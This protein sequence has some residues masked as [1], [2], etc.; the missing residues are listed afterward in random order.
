MIFIL[1]VRQKYKINTIKNISKYIVNRINMSNAHYAKVK[2][3]IKLIIK[4]LL[5]K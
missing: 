3:K 5:Y 1:A 2:T 4:Y